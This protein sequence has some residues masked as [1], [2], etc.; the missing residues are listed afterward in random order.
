[1]ARYLKVVISLALSTVLAGCG[2]GG[3]AD[4]PAGVTFQV[5]GDPEDLKLYREVARAYEQRSGVRVGLIEVGDRKDHL[6]KLTASIAARRAPDVFLINHRNMGG[7]AARNAIA[8]VG[9]LI[10]RDAYYPVAMAAFSYR[11]RLQCVPQNASSLVVFYNRTLFESQGVALPHDGW[12]FAEFVDAARKLSGDG[13]YGVAI[14]P[15]TVRAAPFVWGAGGRLVDDLDDPQRFVLDSENARAGLDSLLSL[16]SLG[17]APDVREAQAQPADERF[18]A[19]GA[20]MFLSSR[21]EVPTLRTI[22]TFEWDVA[23]FPVIVQPATVLHSDGYCV[24]RGGRVDAARR[25]VAFA[26]GP[27]GQR[28]LARGGR[29]VPSLKAVAE[30]PAFLRSTPPGSNRV[31]L[32]QIEYMQRLPTTRNWTRIEEAAD[33]ALEQAFYGRLT[34]DEALRRIERETAGRF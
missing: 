29:T 14:E 24:S 6:A 11:G 21:R 16:R 31:F 20:A 18:L 9:R 12:S 1:M 27:D 32:D 10:D 5:A 34:L 19:G 3:G 4:R 25:F 17:F 33:L 23:P 2:A 13:R 28:I 26:A 30:S 7:Y 15:S 22:R 8:P